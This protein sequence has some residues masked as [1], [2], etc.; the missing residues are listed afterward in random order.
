MHRHPL[1]DQRVI[2]VAGGVPPQASAQVIGK[3]VNNR[4]RGKPADGDVR[5]PQ[6]QQQ[7]KAPRRGLI[8]DFMPPAHAVCYYMNMYVTC[9]FKYM[10]MYTYNVHC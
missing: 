6:Q 3:M 10:H 7:R 4:G 1:D 5:L 2:N 9:A 8:D